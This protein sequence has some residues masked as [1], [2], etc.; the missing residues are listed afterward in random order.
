MIDHE[1]GVQLVDRN[2]PV[3]SNCGHAITLPATSV[4]RP[5][6][7]GMLRIAL[8]DSAGYGWCPECRTRFRVKPVRK[9][10][11]PPPEQQVSSIP[12]PSFARRF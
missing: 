4:I 5:V 6:P 7:A 11:G 12:D 8:T 2:D 3:C 9:A 10:A 1:H